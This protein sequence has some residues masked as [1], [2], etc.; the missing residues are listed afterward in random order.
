MLSSSIELLH[1]VQHDIAGDADGTPGTARLTLSDA[2]RYA[3]SGI[4][5]RS[6]ECRL[7]AAHGGAHSTGQFSTIVL[8][9]IG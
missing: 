8:F 2:T 9:T 7:G 1:C 3:W 6:V 5:D 4:A